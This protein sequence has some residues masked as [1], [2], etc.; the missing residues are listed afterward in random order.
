[1]L[2]AEQ[3]WL[4]LC[5]ELKA[6]KVKGLKVKQVACA[7]QLRCRH[8]CTAT[9]ASRL[10]AYLN[11]QEDLASA[12]AQRRPEPVRTS[13][14]TRPC[15][16]LSALAT[17]RWRVYCWTPRRGLKRRVAFGSSQSA[18]SPRGPLAPASQASPNVETSRSRTTPLLLALQRREASL[19]Q[20]LMACRADVPGKPEELPR[21][22]PRNRARAQSSPV[23]SKSWVRPHRSTFGEG[24]LSLRLSFAWT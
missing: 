1:M 2:G 3:G 14:V 6:P 7:T 19:V 15:S 22:G 10:A 5:L 20:Q 24:L 11:A 16:M 9:S 13:L 12:C 21:T 18:R 17:R 8:L 23:P 4:Q